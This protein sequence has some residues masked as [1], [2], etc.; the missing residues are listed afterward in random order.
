MGERFIKR[1]FDIALERNLDS[2]YV[3]VFEKH[4]ALIELFERYGFDRVGIKKSSSGMEIVLERRLDKIKNDVVLDY[5]RIPIGA[6]RHFVISIY[7]QWHS[8]LL[9]DSLLKTENPNILEDVSHCNSIHKIYLTA[10]TGVKDLVRG[11]TL[12]IYRTQENGSAY[13]TSVITSLCVVEES[14]HISSFKSCDEFIKFC[15]P[16]SIFSEDELIK[17]YIQKNIRG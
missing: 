11:D 7:P 2:L 14:V 9:P 12:L 5:P 8:R 17:F 16:Y 3:T 10:M 1:V 15:N 4:G 6:R 13:F